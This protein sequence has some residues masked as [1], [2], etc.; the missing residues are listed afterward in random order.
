MV[1]L[2]G[3]DVVHATTTVAR[4]Q[5]ARGG[6][7][8]PFLGSAVDGNGIAARARL[9]DFVEVEHQ[10]GRGVFGRKRA[11]VRIAHDGTETVVSRHD[12]EATFALVESVETGFA[13]GRN[14]RVD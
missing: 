3:A 4:E 1:P 7:T 13:S 10:F 14:S 8:L 12:D 5:F 11:F 2:G 6:H 9:D